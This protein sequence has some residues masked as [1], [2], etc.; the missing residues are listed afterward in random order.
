M[1]HKRGREKIVSAIRELG[2][3]LFQILSFGPME[4]EANRLHKVSH[5]KLVKVQIML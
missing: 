2:D 1:F 5:I 3:Q 4:K